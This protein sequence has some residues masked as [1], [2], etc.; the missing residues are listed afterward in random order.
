MSTAVFKTNSQHIHRSLGTALRYRVYGDVVECWICGPNVD[1][2]I[3]IRSRLVLYALMSAQLLCRDLQFFFV[4]FRFLG[5][6]GAYGGEGKVAGL[7]LLS[8]WLF[9]GVCN[10]GSYQYSEFRLI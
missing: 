7:Q 5:R 10:F 9:F 4:S 1:S 8:W 6:N 2:S 3:L